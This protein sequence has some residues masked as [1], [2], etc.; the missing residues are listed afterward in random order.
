[1]RFHCKSVPILEEG[2]VG[3]GHGY[4]IKQTR[5]DLGSVQDHVVDVPL[6]S[7]FLSPG[8]FGAAGCF[9]LVITIPLGF[10]ALFVLF[11]RFPPLTDVARTGGAVFLVC[12][13]ILYLI[14]GLSGIWPAVEQAVLKQRNPPEKTSLR[15]VPAAKWDEFVSSLGASTAASQAQA[16]RFDAV[17]RHGR[18]PTDPNQ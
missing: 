14:I 7:V 13:L 3:S 10:I 9:A 17:E 5:Y 1:M 15:I 6:S 12:M 18:K 11:D 8:L 2:Y 4:V 16:A